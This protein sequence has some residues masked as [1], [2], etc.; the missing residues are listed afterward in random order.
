MNDLTDRL[1]EWER[2]AQEYERKAR[3]LRQIIDG[4]RALNGEAAHLLRISGAAATPTPLAPA[5][6]VS[7]HGDGPR[8][9]QAI[10]IIASEMPGVWKVSELKDEIHRRG[11]PDPG[12]GAEAALKRLV[13]S[14]EA[15]RVA[16]GAYRIGREQ[17][18]PAELVPSHE[19]VEL[20]C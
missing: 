8:G 4:V 3:A 16:H 2:Q 18:D 10:R 19:E 12:T 20:P 17:V 11:W 7:M 5:V 1:P 14:G 6:L 13:S 15:E 9:R